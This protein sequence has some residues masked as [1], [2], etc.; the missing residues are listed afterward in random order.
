V[1]RGSVTDNRDT[2]P[3]IVGVDGSFAAIRAARWAA[4]VAEKFAAPLQI[5]HAAAD[6]AQRESADA[7]LQSA[8]QAVRVNFK[9]LHITTGRVEGSAEQALIESS[10]AACLIVLGSDDLSSGTA[11]FGESI[12]PVVAWRGGAVSPTRQPVVVGV[13]HDQDSRVAIPASFELADRLGVGLIAVHAWTFQRPVGDVTLPAAILWRQVET[14]AQQHLSETL[15]GWINLYP[16]VEVTQV[17]VP[18]HPSRALLR[19]SQD[20]QMLVVGSRASG[21]PAGA[22]PGSIGLDLL[23]HSTIPVMFCH[24]VDHG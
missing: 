24:S 17:V 2:N 12:C 20:A 19:C 11:V 3:V 8:H 22:L 14:D 23:R 10:H 9:G 7:I 5:M 15:L 16:N 18:D 13:D 21:P 4:V 1:N 6:P